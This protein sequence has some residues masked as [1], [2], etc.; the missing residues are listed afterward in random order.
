MPV[1][2]R[3]F[4]F[5]YIGPKGKPVFVPTDEGREIGQTVKALVEER[6]EFAPFYT[7]F[8]SP[9]GMC[10]RCMNTVR[11]VFSRSST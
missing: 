6:Y 10:K 9:V 11:I 7:H 2:F 5:S 4:D 1:Q 8:S 3:N